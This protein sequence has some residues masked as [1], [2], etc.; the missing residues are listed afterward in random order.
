MK[1]GRQ[2]RGSDEDSEKGNWK[3]R[4]TRDRRLMKD[5]RKADVEARPSITRN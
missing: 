3:A 4:R 5:E 2:L 1:D